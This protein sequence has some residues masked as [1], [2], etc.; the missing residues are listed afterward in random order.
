MILSS[1]K[2]KKKK[3][4]QQVKK[5]KATQI[6]KEKGKEVFKGTKPWKQQ[7]KQTPLGNQPHL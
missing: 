2:K 4:N 6:S 1:Q 5:A 3:T 7:K